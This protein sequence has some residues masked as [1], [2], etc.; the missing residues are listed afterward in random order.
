MPVWLASLAGSPTLAMTI[1][2]KTRVCCFP[3]VSV[4]VYVYTRVWL[5]EP[6]TSL[7]RYRCWF[8]LWYA[9]IARSSVWFQAG[10]LK[11]LLVCTCVCVCMSISGYSKGTCQWVWLNESWP[12]QKYHTMLSMWQRAWWCH[13][14]LCINP[15]RHDSLSL[16]CSRTHTCTHTHAYTAHHEICKNAH[17]VCACIFII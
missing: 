6:R 9:Y 17:T 4:C 10:M 8:T 12:R 15:V 14:T 3:C 5:S 7:K 16:P 1:G 2:N 11:Y 13:R